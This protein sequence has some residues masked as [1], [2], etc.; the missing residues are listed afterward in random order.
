MAYIYGVYDANTSVGTDFE[1]QSEKISRSVYKK[2]DGKT[3]EDRVREAK[4]KEELERIVHTECYRDYNTGA[5]DTAD[6]F[7]THK[8][9]VTMG[10]DRV[11]DSHYYLD[12]LTV[13]IDEYFYTLDGDY[14]LHPFGFLQPENNINCRCVL[15]Y[16]RQEKK[17]VGEEE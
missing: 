10:D 2:I 11:R 3:W 16:S 17:N 9:W 15:E 12:G 5:Y 13:G 1:P 7:A 6:G 8:T 14:A 4:T